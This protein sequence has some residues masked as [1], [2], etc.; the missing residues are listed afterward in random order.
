M[1]QSKLSASSSDSLDICHTPPKRPQSRLGLLSLDVSLKE[2]LDVCSS[3]NALQRTS[4]EWSSPLAF[5]MAR[6]TSLPQTCLRD[7]A[8]H[9]ALKWWSAECIKTRP[10]WN[11]LHR[12][13]GLLATPHSYCRGTNQ[14]AA[15][16]PHSLVFDVIYV[17]AQQMERSS[18]NQIWSLLREKVNHC[19]KPPSHCLSSLRGFIQDINP[20]LAT[21]FMDKC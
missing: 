16:S 12:L 4:S 19:G 1:S 2:L 15:C 5:R 20:I 10:K 11:F 3:C 6:V 7:E 21:Q 17:R 14:Q 18:G 8:P 9:S 13:R